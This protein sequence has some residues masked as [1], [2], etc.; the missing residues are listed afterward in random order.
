MISEARRNLKGLQDCLE[1]VVTQ[2]E[3]SGKSPGYTNNVVK[4]VRAWLRYNDLLI[5]R[6][7]KIK[8]STATPTIENEQIPSRE[9]LAKLFRNS[10][11]GKLRAGQELREWNV[12][13][14]SSGHCWLRDCG[15]MT[16]D[17]AKSNL[18]QLGVRT[19]HRESVNSVLIR[20]YSRHS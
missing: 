15:C 10:T 17:I 5:T 1:D 6:R 19:V 12:D 14:S 3:A 9:E 18:P 2:L 16:Y 4:T 13:K 8:N 20:R 11:S 7:I